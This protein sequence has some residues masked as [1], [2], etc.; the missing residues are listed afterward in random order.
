MMKNKLVPVT[1]AARLA[2]AML[3][4]VTAL[5]SLACDTETPI[6]P[7][8]PDTTS[9]KFEGKTVWIGTQYQGDDKGGYHILQMGWKG[10][11]KNNVDKIVITLGKDYL[12]DNR[13]ALLMELVKTD[14]PEVSNVDISQAD[15][16]A[17][18]S[19]LNA[20]L[21]AGSGKTVVN[22]NLVNVTKVPVYAMIRDAIIRLAQTARAGV[23]RG[24]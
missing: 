17:L 3:V 16:D 15:Y 1:A 24:A 23:G 5:L 7:S 8:I 12:E 18:K 9:V 20:A 2:A 10:E 14:P 19:K 6:T 11:Y 22:G 21:P 13:P 4:V